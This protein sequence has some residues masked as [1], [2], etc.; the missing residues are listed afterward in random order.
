M[1][2]LA[3]LLKKAETNQTK[4]EIPPGLLHTVRTS[5]GRDVG[6]Q[7][8]LLPGVLALV[9]LAAGGLLALYLGRRP[10]VRPPVVQQPVQQPVVAAAVQKP[11][12]SAVHPKPVQQLPAVARPTVAKVAT[13]NQARS[14]SRQT[15]T[16]HAIKRVAVSQ[17]TPSAPVKKAIVKDR[18]AIDALLFAART[19][20]VR[21]EYPFALKQYQKA[22]EADPLNY[23]IM[24]NLASTML[25]LGMTD[26]A[27][28]IANRALAIKPDYPSAMVNAGIALG[29]LGRDSGAKGMFTKALAVD[30]AN[31]T[32]LF[33]LALTRERSGEFDDALITYRRLA[34]GGDVRGLMGQGRLYERRGN[35]GEALKFYRE[36][37]AW[38]DAG[39]RV[40][41][42]A[43]ERIAALDQ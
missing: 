39:Q 40:K 23:R 8:Y 12:S 38:P 9:A 41:D 7:K 4:G 5:A 25:Q 29:R 24:N 6:L 2:I 14:R 1:S 27:L 16:A 17:Q 28:G 20:E 22:L 35:R 37:T 31:R 43:R 42:A 26:E 21:H 19:A 15:Q 10:A 32:A 13:Q 36:V 33:S 30:P 34:E 3:N 11:V 18:A